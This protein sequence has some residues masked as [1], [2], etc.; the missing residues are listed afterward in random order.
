MGRA[1]ARSRRLQYQVQY[2]PDTGRILALHDSRGRKLLSP[3]PGIDLFSVVC[4]RTDA[5]DE[6]R[7][8]AFYLRDLEKEKI[9]VSC[10]RDWSPVRETARGVTSCSVTESSDRIT[11]TR[12]IDMAGVRRLLQSFTL[13][14]DDPVIRVDVELNSSR[15]GR[16]IFLPRHLA[17]RVGRLAW[18]L[19]QRGRNGR[20]DARQLPGACRN[21]VTAESYAAIGDAAGAVVLLCPDAPLVQFG[22]F[23]F[24]PPRDEIPRH[25]EPL[26]L[27]WPVNNYW[28]TNFPRRELRTIR[29]RYGFVAVDEL[30]Q[31]TIAAHAA[32]FGTQPFVWPVTGATV[33]ASSGRFAVANDDRSPRN[34][35]RS[36]RRAYDLRAGRR[37]GRRRQ[38]A[39]R[40]GRLPPRRGRWR[41]SRPASEFARRRR[42]RARGL[43]RRLGRVLRDRRPRRGR[44]VARRRG[45]S[46]TRASR[47]RR[48][49]RDTFGLPLRHR[50]R[51]AAWRCSG[52]TGRRRAR[53]PGR[54]HDHAGHR[55]RRRRDGGR[56]AP[57]QP[58]TTRP[59]CIGGHVPVSIDG[60]ACRCGGTGARRPRPRPGRCPRSAPTW[61]GFAESSLAREERLD[62]ETL[63]R[64]CDAGDAVAAA[65]LERSC[66]VW[67]TLAVALIH[68]YDPEVLV[69]GGAVMRRSEEVLAADSR[70]RA[71]PRLDT[72]AEGADRAR[73]R[74]ATTR[75]STAPSRCSV[76]PRE[77]RL[78]AAP[79]GR[80]R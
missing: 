55:D 61:P 12:E 39:G 17:L 65:V 45:S 24:G 25:A 47:S 35:G 27:A 75:R 73:R 33:E 18:L 10:W 21:W 40:R 78:R 7:R 64:H 3:R 13:T 48:W 26:L 19:R 62:Y 63:F 77:P 50:K 52:S 20:V 56:A 67:A 79:G 9:D 69:L 72:G 70:P 37:L 43:H 22:T 1:S 16:A 38:D 74:S 44:V 36:R 32:R 68:A 60:R 66:D 8:Y 23:H 54:G 34:R 31:K 11:L 80:R 15:F 4:E 5:L 30:D 28:D 41:R 59:G 46:K 57:C 29:L 49:S 2:D 6:S 51:R 14:A 58:A 71:R 53:L 76:L 42:G